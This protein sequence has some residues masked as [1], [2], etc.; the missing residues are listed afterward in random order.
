MDVGPGYKY[1]DKIRGG[2]QWYMLEA[3]TFFKHQ[4]YIQKMKTMKWY[5]SMDKA[6]LSNYQSKELFLFKGQRRQ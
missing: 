5:L 1:I 2:V 3:K 4:F 6:L